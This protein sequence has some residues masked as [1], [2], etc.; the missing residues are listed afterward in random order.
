[1]RFCSKLLC[2]RGSRNR[3]L[4][5][6]RD[7]GQGG[8][9]FALPSRVFFL[10]YYVIGILPSPS[11]GAAYLIGESDMKE[12]CVREIISL[13]VLDPVERQSTAP[14]T[15]PSPSI[16]DIWNNIDQHSREVEKTYQS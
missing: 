5:N 12:L 6:R 4:R 2:N 10:S 7:G 16:H 13:K 8:L 3:G 14:S 1:M 9:S 11:W 15:S